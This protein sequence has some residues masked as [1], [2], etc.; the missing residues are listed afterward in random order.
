MPP[1]AARPP[2]RSAFR[3]RSSVIDQ[4]GQNG[5]EAKLDFEFHIKVAEATGN[6]HFAR[7][8]D[9]IGGFV[10]PRQQ[11]R[12]EVDPSA[13]QDAYLR[14]LQR[15]HRLIEQAIWAGDEVVAR[16]SMR[17]HLVGSAYRYQ[18]W[19]KEAERQAT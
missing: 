14:M 6:P 1:Y 2:T 9:F 3:K 10:V 13:G 17:A 5:S 11:V 19:A 4:A 8:M 16:D 15:E 7:F 18:R 12:V